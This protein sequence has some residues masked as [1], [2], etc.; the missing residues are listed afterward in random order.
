VFLALI[1]ASILATVPGVALNARLVTVPL[2][3]LQF[4]WLL[5]VA[6]ACCA[7]GVLGLTLYS[8]VLWRDDERRLA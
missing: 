5:Y 1:Y 2:G 7:L 8:Y 6:I 4:P 3:L